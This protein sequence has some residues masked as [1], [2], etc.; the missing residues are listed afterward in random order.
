VKAVEKESTY[1]KKGTYLK[2][3]KKAFPLERS[4]KKTDSY[5]K[6]QIGNVIM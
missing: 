5:K 6:Q 1:E 3:S 2:M 4:R